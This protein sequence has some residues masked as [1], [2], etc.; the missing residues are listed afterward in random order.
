MAYA[1]L[2]IFYVILNKGTQ[3]QES[4]GGLQGR[5]HSDDEKE[6]ENLKWTEKG[7]RLTS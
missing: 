6:P 2:R 3:R 4:S 7:S 1:E 5:N